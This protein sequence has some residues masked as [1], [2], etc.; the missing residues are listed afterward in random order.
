M[1]ISAVKLIII[2]LFL[3]IF[4][5]ALLTVK[6]DKDVLLD[7]HQICNSS[8]SQ[9]LLEIDGKLR[10]TPFKSRVW[11]QYKLYQFDA[12]FRLVELK[13]L[14]TEIAKW[15]DKEEVPLRF[16]ISIYILYAKIIKTEGNHT[17]GDQYLNKAINTL[18]SVN[19]VAVD[20]MIII[21]I[22]NALN[23]L[24]KNQQ[25]YDMLIDLEKKYFKRNNVMFKL[26]LYENLGHFSYRLGKLEEHI[27]LR[28]KAITWAKQQGNIQRVATAVYNLA[29]AY[30]MTKE[31]TQA[32]DYFDKAEQY[33][34][35]SANYFTLSM[36]KFRRSEI[37]HNRGNNIKA[38]EYFRLIDKK[39]LPESS[40]EMLN[41]LARKIK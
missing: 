14:K 3:F 38:R 34:K 12:L 8:P 6:A 36:S 41:A 27:L 37:E 29:R 26:E 15:I 19:E 18:N 7:I 17:L 9:C 31:Y 20:P 25:G 28:I 30:Q 33:A 1:D 35:K 40:D 13:K 2:S 11:F 22:A 23:Y 16:K 24:N 32:I 10:S 39:A 5:S 21:Q 4:P